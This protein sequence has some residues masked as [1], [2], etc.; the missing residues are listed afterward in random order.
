MIIATAGHVD[1]GKTSLVRALTGT[2]TDRLP[3]EQRRGM[4]IEPGFA[5]ASF[6]GAA[7]LA[8]VDV[9][10][11][12]RLLRQMMAGVAAVDAVLLVVAA[13]DGPMPQTREHLA[14]LSL[15]GVQ[16]GAVVLTKTDRV[17]AARTA[18]VAAA[19]A[20]VLQATALAGAPMFALSTVTGDGLPALRQ[21][22]VQWQRAWTPRSAAGGFRLV[23]D[24]CFTQPGA[25]AVVTGTV[26]AGRLRRDETLC[27]SP[28]GQPVRVRGLQVHGVAVDQVQAG[29]RCALNLVGAD[30]HAIARGDML[31][32]PEL[33]AP[34]QRRDVRLQL[35]PAARA[36]N[37]DQALHLH[38]GAL[39][40]PVRAVPLHPARLNPGES[41]WVQLVLAQPV[42]A[43]GLD[44]F[45][46]RDGATLAGGGEVIDPFAPA[47]GRARPERLADLQA[48]ALPDAGAA[49]QALVEHHPEGVEWP[50][51]ARAWNLD[52]GVALRRA[53]NLHELPHPGGLRVLSAAAWQVVL[54]A[55]DDTLAACHAQQPHALGPDEAA[56]QVALHLVLNKA[57]DPV[58]RQAALRQRL[59][60]GTV[61]R[62]GFHL[63]L[64][65]H[66]PQLDAADQALLLRL[67]ALM[68]PMGLRPPPLG[69]LAPLLNLD[70]PAATTALQRIAAL[71]HL[72]QAAKNRFFLPEVMEGL[73]QVL[74][75][76]AAAAP[77]GR[78]DAASFRDR[79]GVGRNLTIQLLEFFDRRG[80]TRFAN[81]RRT[82]VA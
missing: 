67:R 76:T 74:R 66:Q 36:L 54:L 71:G 44:R 68:E 33:H 52:D 63:R 53:M 77:D 34:T 69:E 13:D 38:L 20:G 24:R 50:L 41:G 6:D 65:S 43:L 46:L 28:Q 37:S 81:E 55:V 51:L 58:V 9:P 27:L 78:F 61:L 72:V 70:L 49:L 32:A 30:R 18:Q 80:L 45:V 11:H 56:F 75:D 2:D 21:H 3:E 26:V 62:Q 31:V 48:M 5:H 23:I 7:P 59:A 82:L 64:P 42:S 29:Q 1:H 57:V 15:L 47:R 73:V 35:L 60:D 79:S 25:G 17:D 19:M 14:V 12:E 8:F 22:L 10:G 16:Q 4:T 39:A 40:V